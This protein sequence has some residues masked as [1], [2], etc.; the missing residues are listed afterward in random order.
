MKQT[1]EEKRAYQIF[2]HLLD[3]ISN[4]DWFLAILDATMLGFLEAI[5]HMNDE[6]AAHRL[7]KKIW[8]LLRILE[9]APHA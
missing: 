7:S 1:P 9:K 5:I 6:K 4:E 8:S 3:A 2:S